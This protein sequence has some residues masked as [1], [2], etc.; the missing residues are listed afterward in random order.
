MKE[1]IFNYTKV[2]SRAQD[3]EGTSIIIRKALGNV[4]SKEFGINNIG[5]EGV[6]SSHVKLRFSDIF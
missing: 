4:R 2:F 1:K 6:V 5:E 3:D